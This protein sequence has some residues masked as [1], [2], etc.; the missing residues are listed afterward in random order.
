MAGK[1]IFDPTQAGRPLRVAAFMSGSGT[2]VIKLLEAQEPSYEVAF[3]FSDTAG[4]KC[5]GQEIARRFDLPYFAYDV[6][7][8]HDK[9]GLKRSVGTP[10]GLAARRDY[11]QVA[12][13]LVRAFGIDV[14]A[15][16]GY[17]SFLTLTG[18]INVHP[19]DLSLVDADG[20]RRF[21]G[22]DAVMD[23]IVAG[24]K[25]LRSSTLF[26]DLGVDSGPLLMVSDPIAVELPASLD[27]LKADPSRLRQVADANQERLK[28]AGDWM[29]FPTTLEL[30]GQG[31]LGLTD[32][33]VA[34][35]DGELKPGGVRPSELS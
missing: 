7:R 29:V 31:R 35:L 26:T 34:T 20:K 23:A 22:D 28:E 18:A 21:V 1:P 15:L 9:R 24:Q 27:E 33:G 4:D 5:R 32:D 19:A 3:I 8:Y 13:R 16:G 17:M 25:E 11:D 10:E 6:R 2:N 12:A 14:I 30:I